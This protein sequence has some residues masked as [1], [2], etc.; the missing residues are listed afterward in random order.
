M[1]IGIRYRKQPVRDVLAGYQA[2]ELYDVATG[3]KIE[4]L[5]SVSVDYDCKTPIV[6]T[7][8]IYISA[9]DVIEE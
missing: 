9:V 1:K 2:V 3:A 8:K 6:A 7:A 4:G 5:L